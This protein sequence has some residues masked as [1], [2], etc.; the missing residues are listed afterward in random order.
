MTDSKN[1]LVI[2]GVN[3]SSINTD[4]NNEFTNNVMGLLLKDGNYL[5]YVRNQTFNLCRI[6]ILQNWNSLRFVRN[7]THE[8]CSIAISENPH[9]IQYVKDLTIQLCVDALRK[10]ESVICYLKDYI[11]NYKKI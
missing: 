11:K 7:Q 10:D 2:N 9:A 8:L 4:Y 3:I 1:N 5:E 6:A